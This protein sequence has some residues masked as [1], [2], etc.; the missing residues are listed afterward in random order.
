MLTMEKTKVVH[1]VRTRVKTVEERFEKKHVKG[2]GPDAEFKDVS[3]GWFIVMEGWPSALGL[4][5]EK[6]VISSGDMVELTI[7]RM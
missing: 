1:K 4:G 7:A 5:S 3:L 2:V 6:P